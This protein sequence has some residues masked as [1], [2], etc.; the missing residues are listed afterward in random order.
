MAGLLLSILIS[1]SAQ[2]A[3]VNA[4]TAPFIGLSGHP[5]SITQFQKIIDVMKAFGMNTYRIVF[6][7]QWKGG[8]QSNVYTYVNYYLTHTPSNWYIIVDRNHLH[9]ATEYE[10]SLARKN[11]STVR[12]NIF[13]T[14]SAWKNN[15]RVIVEFINEYVSSDFYSRMQTLVN[16]IRNAGYTNKV[17]FNRWWT[18]PWKVV[19]DPVGQTYQGF[20][21]Y[22]DCCGV[23][24]VESSMKTAQSM[25]IKLLNTEI[26]AD[27]K[28]YKYFSSSEVQTLNSFLLWSYNRGVGNL[29]WVNGDL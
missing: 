14:L 28:E 13:N 2:T 9:P 25:G 17:V 6:T 7:P 4:A 5:T 1:L 26:G 29:I 21:A 3:S 27:C 15:P 22:F 23:S 10:S 8:S 24:G 16:D 12:S 19:S 11:W 18:I 20:H